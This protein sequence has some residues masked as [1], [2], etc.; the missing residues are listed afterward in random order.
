MI[1]VFS[2]LF[3]C[4]LFI[5]MS[6]NLKEVL[7][8]RIFASLSFVLFLS[9]TSFAATGAFFNVT[10][11]GQIVT[12]STT[13]PN[14][15]Y[16]NAGIKVNSSGHN[17]VSAGCT[18]Y[19]NGYCLF[20]V[21]NTSPKTLTISG[22]AGKPLNMTLCLN[23]KG[24]LTC[25]EYSIVENFA[26][27]GN[28]AGS[29]TSISLCMVS[30]TGA[31]SNCQPTPTDGTQALLDGP[32]VIALNPAATF[33]YIPNYNNGTIVQCA[34]NSSTRT[35]S[36]CVTTPT[37]GTQSNLNGSNGITFNA[38][39]TRAYISNQFNSNVLLCAVNSSTGALSACNSTVFVNQPFGVILN[40]T[41]S[42]AYI[43]SLGSNNVQKCSVSAST[44]TL[45]G[46]E[47]SQNVP[48]PQGVTLNQ[49]N[50]IVY[51]P[52]S[53]GVILFCAVSPQTG[54]FTICNPTV[55]VSSAVGF[56]G[57]LTLSFSGKW[58]YVANF[59]ST[60]S[61]C[62]VS[63]TTGALSGCGDSGAGAAFNNP[64]GITLIR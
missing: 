41:E 33:A 22:S 13:V 35:L 24:P 63:L 55:S 8:K 1:R 34:I 59:G 54:A 51:V 27:V 32:Q 14:H 11:S 38:D 19:G 52:N 57:P 28:E 17:L 44:G 53:F 49:A 39:G 31:F 42:F 37:D 15:I 5:L 18:P 4:R 9:T 47:S 46:C 21:S 7:M 29:P 62:A 10:S 20:S 64:V 61:K 48:Q 45:S 23:G 58:A 3:V 25:Q 2:L 12:I 40:S 43:V 16:P 36:G 30:N 26:Y 50:T 6:V 60:V 56:N